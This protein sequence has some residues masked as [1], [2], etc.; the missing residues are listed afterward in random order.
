M[1]S[2]EF[3]G[4]FF[5][6]FQ[7]LRISYEF[8]LQNSHMNFCKNSCTKSK[9]KKKFVREISE[10]RARILDKERNLCTNLNKPTR[11]HQDILS[12]TLSVDNYMFSLKS[13]SVKIISK[14]STYN[15]FCQDHSPSV[16]KLRLFVCLKFSL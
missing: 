11:L 6:F 7:K 12:K 15:C 8:H 5:K 9:Q 13:K 1:N 14:F 2:R 3:V 16:C 10:I 4:I